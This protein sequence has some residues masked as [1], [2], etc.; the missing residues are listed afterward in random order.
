MLYLVSLIDFPSDGALTE[1]CFTKGKVV[2][3]ITFITFLFYK[4][5]TVLQLSRNRAGVPMVIKHTF[6]IER[7][8][9][10]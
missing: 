8:L 3:A 10:C 2:R 9:L 1:S 5:A 6:I 4:K 7:A